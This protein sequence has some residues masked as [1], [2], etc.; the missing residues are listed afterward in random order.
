M[1]ESEPLRMELSDEGNDCDTE[2]VEVIEQHGPQGYVPYFMPL[3]VW[4][5][6]HDD[7]P[8]EYLLDGCASPNDTCSVSVL[9]AHQVGTDAVYRVAE[10]VYERIYI[11]SNMYA[12]HLKPREYVV[13]KDKYFRTIIIADDYPLPNPIGDE[14]GRH[15]DNDI[16]ICLPEVL[17]SLHTNYVYSDGRFGKGCGI[18]RTEVSVHVLEI[19]GLC[20]HGG[21][22]CCERERRNE[23]I[24]TIAF[25]VVK[26]CIP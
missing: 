10:E 17:H 12:Q 2:Y 8:D 14:E 15:E 21:I 9:P 26:Q 5:G 19:T 3:A 4:S 23:D 18:Y 1:Q 7:G 20:Y 22:V 16:A 6:E 24:P 11:V 13:P 25:T